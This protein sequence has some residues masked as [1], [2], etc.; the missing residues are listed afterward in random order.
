MQQCVSRNL[1]G[2]NSRELREKQ[3]AFAG[4]T[5]SDIIIPAVKGWKAHNQQNGWKNSLNVNTTIFTNPREAGT[6]QL[7]ICDYF[8]HPEMPGIHCPRLGE[9]GGD[10]TNKS[11]C[12]MW[13]ESYGKNDEGVFNEGDC[14]V[15]V[16]HWK[17]NRVSTPLN[18]P[19]I[20]STT[21]IA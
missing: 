8:S 14:K 7:P 9:N 2:G 12:D 16:T 5:L 11:V 1:P 4:L 15:K 10:L 6:V 13:D 21:R 19:S 20:F 3:K 18:L 17:K